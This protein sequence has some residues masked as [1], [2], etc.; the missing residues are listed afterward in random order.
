MAQITFETPAFLADRD[1]CP[2]R[3]V[4]AAVTNLCQSALVPWIRYPIRTRSVPAEGCSTK[5]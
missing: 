4:A 1:R 2:G 3:L 5:W